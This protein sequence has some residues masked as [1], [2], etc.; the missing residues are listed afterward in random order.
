[1]NKHNED[2]PNKLNGLKTWVIWER[3]KK[4]SH[5]Y[6]DEI[7]VIEPEGSYRDA[8][9]ELPIS[10][11]CLIEKLLDSDRGWLVLGIY[12]V[13]VESNGIPCQKIKTVLYRFKLLSKVLVDGKL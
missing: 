7:K 10:G 3:E 13:Q 8:Q 11:E 6:P 9:S 2:S 5:H 1:M 12:L 4:L